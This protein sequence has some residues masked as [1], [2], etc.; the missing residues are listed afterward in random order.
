[1][2]INVRLQKESLRNYPMR[3]IELTQ[4]KVALVD[5]EDYEWLSQW[6][7][8]V[9]QDNEAFYAIRNYPSKTL[10][11]MHNAI[12]EY[13]YGPISEGYTVD[14]VDLRSLNNQKENFRL[15][16]PT[17]QNQNRKILS[18]NTSGFVGVAWHKAT[19]KF[20][21]RITV[22]KKRIWL[23]LFDDPIEAARVRDRAVI[24]HY[25]DFA[26]LNFPTNPRQDKEVE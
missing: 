2:L 23:G 1:M 5:D 9:R 4:G 6:K 26:K 14:H 18:S 24:E 8:H 13:H 20:Q 17:Q 3:E 7:W 11:Q 21:A 25:G 12:W 10:L 15:A 16:T 19:N 22:D